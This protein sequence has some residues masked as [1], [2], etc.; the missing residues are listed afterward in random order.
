V[1]NSTST[2]PQDFIYRIKNILERDICVHRGG[3]LGGRFLAEGCTDRATCLPCLPNDISPWVTVEA[4]KLAIEEATRAYSKAGAADR[5]KVLIAPGVKHQVTAQQRKA[6]L[7]W[8]E[9]WLQRA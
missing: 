3:A 5:L 2:V 4:R 1:R 6:A 7:D 9:R 8:F